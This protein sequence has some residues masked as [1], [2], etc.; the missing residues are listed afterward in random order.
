MP[1]IEDL[2][3]GFM[4]ARKGKR[5]M[6]WRDDEPATLVWAEVLDEGDPEVDVKFRDQVFEQKAPFSATPK[7]LF[8]T[9]NRFRGILWGDKNTAIAYDYWWNTRNS[10]TYIIDPSQQNGKAEIIFDRSYQ[11]TYS[12]PGNFVTTENAYGKEV[13][14]MIDGKA[15][16]MGE[17]FS[18]RGQFPF[19]DA[20]GSENKKQRAPL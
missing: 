15:F 9:I 2:P 6:Q 20:D 1:L 4:A 12:D 16:L 3:Q 10:K 13:L 5:S 19:I 18:E 17:G 8:K 11:D 14:E 7:K